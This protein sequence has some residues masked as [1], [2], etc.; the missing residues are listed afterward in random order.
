MPGTPEH[1]LRV[2]VV[3][4]GPSGF[5]AIEHLLRQDGLAVEIDLFDRLPTPYGLV[6]GG[7]APDHQ[8]IK[9]VVKAYE[10]LASHPA[11]RFLGH[12][13]VGT[14]V[15]PA[16]LAAHYHAV[17]WAVGA[18]TDR[19]L[20]IPGEGLAGSHAATEFVGWYNGHPDYRDLAFD[21]SQEAVAVI[22][23]GNVAMDVT[24]ILAKGA[25]ALAAT[26][27]APHALEALA[28]SRVREITVLARRGP[29]QAACTTPEL[30]ELGELAEADV[31]AHADEVALDDATRAA[32]EAADDRT[33]LR[34]CEILQ[35]YAGRA[36][37]GKRRRV[38]LRFLL[39][40]AA[41]EGEG[42]V[43]GV[44]AVRNRLVA[45]E[46]G[47]VRAVATDTHETIPAGLVFRS[48][49]YRGVPLDGVPFDAKRG[50]IPN[51]AGRV[52]RE[53]G[54]HEVLPGQYCVGWIKRG[55][56]GVIGTNKPDAVETAERLLDDLREGRLPAAEGGRAA[57]DA[58]L[59]ARGADVVTWADWRRL[60]AL[61]VAAGQ[62]L[63]RPRVKFSR[64]DDMLGAVRA[65]RT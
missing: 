9:S 53:A 62:P 2:A 3:G 12:V 45:G 15:T 41:L 36:A 5:Y 65:A 25:D 60:D 17:V 16:E 58:L 44:R 7:V 14:D 23:I 6:R 21:L 8:K 38:T 39:S 49:G 32:L 56:S 51:A 20:G 22:G 30:R 24:R 31:A 26:D 27:I 29:A 47:D 10:R 11:V 55:P 52:L 46:G 40:P 57:L 54:S 28:A 50:T 61:E 59:A 4:A 42:R 35:A 48:V 19:A 18:Q 63:G 1:P 37:T 43:T 34:N 64:I 33:A 13:R